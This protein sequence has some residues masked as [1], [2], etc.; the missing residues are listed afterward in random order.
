MRLTKQAHKEIEK[1]LRPGDYAVDA[2]AGNGYDTQFLARKVGQGGHVFAIDLQNESTKESSHLISRDGLEK[3]VTFF[4]ACHSQLL[5]LIPAGMNGK[6]RTVTFNLG[7]LPSGNKDIITTPKST[8]P[9]LLQAYES[10]APKGIISL[11]A[12]RG[13]KGGQLEYDQLEALIK[14]K[15]WVFQRV[16]GNESDNCPVLFLIKKY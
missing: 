12:Y 15:K 2:T 10:L 16:P 1:I 8:I 14:E 7:Y 6:I 5:Q 3:Q 4:Q 13:H 9:A 11:I